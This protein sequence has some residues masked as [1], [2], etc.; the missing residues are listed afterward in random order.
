MR[1]LIEKAFAYVGVTV[2]WEGKESDERGVDVASGKT[3]VNV[4]PKYYRPIDIDS[5][6]GDASKAQ[7]ELGWTPEVK[8][9]ELV[10][11]MMK[12]DTEAA[13]ASR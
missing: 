13:Q 7:Q 9:D 3:V 2:R 8:F 4:D 1:E 5:V 10:K 11:I 6:L 12:A